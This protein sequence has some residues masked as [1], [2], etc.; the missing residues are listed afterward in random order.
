MGTYFGAFLDDDDTRLG[1]ALL[2]ANCRRQARRTG[3]DE[4]HVET[5]L[6]SIH[7]TSHASNRLAI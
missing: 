4:H 5:H 7:V 3:A 6:F 2:D 1:T